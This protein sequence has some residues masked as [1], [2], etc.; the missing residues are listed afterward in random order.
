[1]A[2]SNGIE[3]RISVAGHRLENPVEHLS[4]DDVRDVA[5]CLNEA[6][7]AALAMRRL[8][9]DAQQGDPAFYL[10]AIAELA[11]STFRRIDACTVRLEGSPAIGNFATEF[12]EE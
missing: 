11:R 3:S 9:I 6:A 4:N 5:R 2:N 12:A 10:T 1:M 8:A 7:Y